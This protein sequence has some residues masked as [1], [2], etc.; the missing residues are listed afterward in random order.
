MERTT[1]EKEQIELAK[2]NGSI[3]ANKAHGIELLNLQNE[4]SS[5]KAQLEKF[6]NL[7]MVEVDLKQKLTTQLEE[8]RQKNNV[9]NFKMFYRLLVFFWL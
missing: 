2:M 1:A 3:E 8:Q 7:Y 5:V 9:S 6:E 4:L